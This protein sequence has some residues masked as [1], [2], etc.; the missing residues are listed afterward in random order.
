VAAVKRRACSKCGKNRAEKFFTSARGRVCSY[1]KRASRRNYSRDAHLGDTYGITQAEYEWMIEQQGGVCAG[2]L[3][4]RRV[5]DVDHDH[6]LE[7]AGVPTRHTVRGGLCRS[8]NK[9]LAM[10]RDDPARLRRLADYLEKGPVWP[11]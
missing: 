1:C 6:K 7:K 3:G 5:Y 2:C 11:L 8:D 9:I 4:T 10:A